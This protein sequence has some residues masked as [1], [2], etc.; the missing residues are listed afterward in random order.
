M[1]PV[2]IGSYTP[3]LWAGREASVGTNGSIAWVVAAAI[4][5]SHHGKRKCKQY[6]Q[7]TL[8]QIGE[9][10]LNLPFPH[11]STFL[12]QSPPSV[13]TF[14]YPKTMQALITPSAYQVVWPPYIQQQQTD[15]GFE[16][17]KPIS[18]QT[19][20]TTTTTM[21]SHYEK[22]SCMSH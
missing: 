12:D 15:A 2:G 8:I 21:V 16:A 13:F 19:T 22:C 7:R 5:I 17:R 18:D 4:C 3:A 14:F 9:G 1:V 10:D 20:T 6:L 11:C